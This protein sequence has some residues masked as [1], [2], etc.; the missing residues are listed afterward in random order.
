[1][2]VNSFEELWV[3]NPGMHALENYTDEGELRGYW[4]HASMD[5]EGF[6]GCCNP[7]HV[8]VLED[9]SFVTSEKGMVRVKVY[10]A[11]GSL[12]SVVAPPSK[13]KDNGKAP[14]VAVDSKDHIYALDYDKNRIRIFEKIQP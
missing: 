2:V 12:Q 1:M 3:V 7:A 8:A 14:D 6:T 4:Q 5:I 13:F 11:S 10:N 9:G